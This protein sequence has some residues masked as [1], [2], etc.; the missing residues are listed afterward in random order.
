M[1]RKIL[2]AIAALVIV[3]AGGAAIAT[4]AG[5]DHPPVQ[6]GLLKHAAGRGDTLSVHGDAVGIVNGRA[7]RK[8]GEIG[9]AD[10]YLAPGQDPD[11]TCIVGVDPD[12]Q[13]YACYGNDDLRDNARALG[14]AVGP[15]GSD[16][17]VAVLVPDAYTEATVDDQQIDVTNNV[18]L[19]VRKSG[20]KGQLKLSG[21]DDEVA[22]EYS[23]G[24]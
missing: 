8:A 3:G 24:G 13:S 17:K 11:Y 21:P 23:F 20:Q 10:V 18:A 6:F 15:E 22:G 7:A 2:A 14:W 1:N 16:V 9:D 19:T 4:G 12:G 5:A